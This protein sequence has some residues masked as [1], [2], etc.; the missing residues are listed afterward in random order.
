MSAYMGH[1]HLDL[2]LGPLQGPRS[3]DTPAAP[4]PGCWFPNIILNQ[5]NPWRQA[6]SSSGAEK[7]EEELGAP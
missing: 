7:T 2:K 6:D 3:R 5:R 4:A 1:T